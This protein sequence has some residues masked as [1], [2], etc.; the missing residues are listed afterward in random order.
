MRK[1]QSRKKVSNKG[2]KKQV[3][4]VVSQGAEGA[5]LWRK[6]GTLPKVSAF[7]GT[8]KKS[9]MDSLHTHVRK[10]L[11][12]VQSV[13]E[14]AVSPRTNEHLRRELQKFAKKKYRAMSKRYIDTAVAYTML[15]L[16][17]C[18]LENA[19]DFILYARIEKGALTDTITQE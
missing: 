8:A 4:T 12:G 6:V 3:E 9:P 10:L 15:D 16:S 1:V 18:N 2:K 17:P 13:S 11:P 7:K 5:V 19:E 14:I